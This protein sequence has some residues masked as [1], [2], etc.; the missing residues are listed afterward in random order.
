[1]KILMIGSG[2]GSW[3][4][5]GE[6]LGAAMGA[7][8]TSAP[9]DADFQWADRVVLVKKHATTHA[10]RAHRFG[11]PIVWDALDFW[12][13]PAHNGYKQDAATFALHSHIKIIK[14]ALVIGATQAMTRAAEGLGVPAAYLPHHSWAGLVPTAPREHVAVVGYEGNPAYLGRWHG[15]LT[16]ACSQRG[17]SFV[18]NPPNLSDVD[19][20]VA[21]RDGPWD[22]WICREWKSGVKVVNAIAAG[23]PLISQPSAAVGE[24]YGDATILDRRDDLEFAL[25][26]A[27]GNRDVYFKVNVDRSKTLTLEAV[28]ARYSEILSTV[29]AS[30]TA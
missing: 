18:V 26:E 20:L 8:V 17:W 27:A 6:Q 13:Q 2:K 5:R 14:P 1:M 7:R 23:R 11:K 29:G 9:T 21:L 10:P 4:M 3:I 19:I 28:A 15:W 30:C 22:G 24:L 25:D 12:S 16:D